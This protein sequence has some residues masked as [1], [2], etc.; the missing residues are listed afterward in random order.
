MFEYLLNYKEKK[1]VL[2]IKNPV[3]IL[4]LLH[5]S[6]TMFLYIFNLWN[7]VFMIKL[8]KFLYSLEKKANSHL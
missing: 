7:L 6:Q 3:I 5:Y 1:E 8:N 4:I 2:D